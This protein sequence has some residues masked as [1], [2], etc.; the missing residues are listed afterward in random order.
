MFNAVVDE[1]Y[2]V[3]VVNKYVS[4]LGWFLVVVM[5]RNRA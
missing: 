1:V 2:I 5:D 3:H 4:V